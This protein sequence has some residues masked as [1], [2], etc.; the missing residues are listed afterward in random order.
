MFLTCVAS[1]RN[2]WPSPCV[3]VEPVARV[4]VVDPGA[5]HVARRGVFD[6]L[7]A[8]GGA[9]VPDGVHVVVLGQH[10]RQRVL[11]AGDDVDHACRHV[12]GFEHLVEIGGAQGV[13]SATARPRRCCPSQWPGATSETKPS[14]GRSS[15]QTSPI[16]PIGS[17]I[18]SV[19][20]RRGVRCTSPSYLSAQAA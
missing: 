4:A 3:F 5:L 1:R 17:G 2:S 19:T 15:G 13:R 7:A 12:R 14:S 8:F 10:L 9:E 20:L 18:A 16:T 11:R 6:R